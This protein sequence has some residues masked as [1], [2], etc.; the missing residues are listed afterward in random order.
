[1]KN[2]HLFKYQ[3]KLYAI[4]LFIFGNALALNS[5]HLSDYISTIDSNK[6]NMIKEF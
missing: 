4:L 5:R 1:M 3:Q 6:Q 2:K